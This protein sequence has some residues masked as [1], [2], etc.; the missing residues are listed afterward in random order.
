MQSI[1]VCRV[2]DVLDKGGCA[3]QSDSQAA[4]HWRLSYPP[5]R[6]KAISNGARSGERLDNNLNRRRYQSCN[7][8][9]PE[10]S[11]AGRD[12][13]TPILVD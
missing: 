4:K 3:S 7:Q 12:S 6:G 8:N 13:P 5:Q 2:L 11:A 9:L 10:W 1:L